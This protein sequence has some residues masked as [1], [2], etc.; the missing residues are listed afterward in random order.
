MLMQNMKKAEEKETILNYE[1][2]KLV[3]KKEKKEKNKNKRR[4]AFSGGSTATNKEVQRL[5][6]GIINS[7]AKNANGRKT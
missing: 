3:A 2:D 5:S 4:N 7:P 6:V 1:I